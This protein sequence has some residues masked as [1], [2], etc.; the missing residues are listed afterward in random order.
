M[1]PASPERLRVGGLFAAALL[2]RAVY[3]FIYRPPLESYYLALANSLITTGVFGFGGTVSTDFEPVYPS[4]LAAASLLFGGRHVLIQLLQTC[5]AA[6][7]AGLLYCLTLQLTASRR[8]ATWAGVL[9]AVH[10]LLIRQ[11]SSASDLAITTTLLVAFALAF[12]RIRDGRTAAVAGAIVGVTV[13]SRSMVAPVIALAAVILLMRPPRHHAAVLA[14]TAAAVM[15]PM[16]VRTYILSG[17]LV[18]TRSGVA[19]YVGNSS[20]TAALLPTYELDLLEPEAHERFVR[21]RPDIDIDDPRFASEFD[22]FLTREAIAHMTERP[23]RTIRQKV[24]NV[25]YQLSP[26]VTP[27]EIPGPATRLRTQ[28]DVVLGVDGSVPRGRLE[29][30]AHAV[31]SLV[32]LVGCAAGVY[33]RRREVRRDAILW[34]IFVTFAI[35]N[36]IYLPA[37][38][39]TS[40]MQLLLMFYSA[41]AIARLREGSTHAAIA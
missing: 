30:A 10:P 29:I 19:L 14:L 36:A 20:H 5:I 17:S 9:F 4:V 38:R 24:L 6:A 8:A 7:G 41:V 32:L 31:S 37:T 21:A 11:A 35:V 15:A 13:L 33:L 2:T 3:L 18:P 27:F 25:A 22:A 1:R 39:Y 12:V 34:A 40:P 16:V 26:F 23:W 28:G